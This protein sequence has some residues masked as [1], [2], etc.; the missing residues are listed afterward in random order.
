VTVILIVIIYLLTEFIVFD[1]LSSILFSPLLR[2][3]LQIHH[4]LSFIFYILQTITAF[5]KKIQTLMQYHSEF[6]EEEL[7]S[8][9]EQRHE[10][11]TTGG[12]F[13]S[14]AEIFEL[15]ADISVIM[16]RLQIENEEI[17]NRWRFACHSLLECAD[18]LMSNGKFWLARM[19]LR[20][21]LDGTIVSPDS[22]LSRSI[23]P[24]PAGSLV[25][26]GYLRVSVLRKLLL[27]HRV[28]GDGRNFV[29]VSLSLLDPA[30][31]RFISADNRMSLQNNVVMVVDVKNQIMTDI[32]YHFKLQ[33][34]LTAGTTAA[35]LPNV[36][37]DHAPICVPM[38]TTAHSKSI[39]DEMFYVSDS[40][41]MYVHVLFSKCMI[42]F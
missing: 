30:L 37:G 1:Y 24:Q 34:Q 36:R 19:Y 4:C 5:Q 29:L 10:S 6:T 31:K 32:Q 20:A 35:S 16:L 21:A 8:K 11:R 38:S 3:Y 40:G 7:H 22:V 41:A 15:E 42:L 23:T 28:L 14:N 13:V 25:A 26:W 9:F 17:A 27:C 33:V 2:S 12:L 18:I 39:R